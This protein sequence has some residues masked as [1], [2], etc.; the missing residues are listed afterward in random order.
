MA[1]GYHVCINCNTHNEVYSTNIEDYGAI[2]VEEPYQE[3][4]QLDQKSPN[5]ESLKKLKADLRVNNNY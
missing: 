1:T 2:L 4:V 3:S 5:T